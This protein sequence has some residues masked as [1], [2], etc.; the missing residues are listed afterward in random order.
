MLDP[1][2]APDAVRARE[3]SRL[4]GRLA[5]QAGLSIHQATKAA[6]VAKEQAKIGAG[7]TNIERAPD[8]RPMLTITTVSG[9]RYVIGL[10]R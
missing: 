8:G 4:A 3:R 10:I 9:G 2:W 6:K 5:R 7:D 1:Q